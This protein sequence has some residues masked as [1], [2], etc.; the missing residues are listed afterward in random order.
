[1]SQNRTGSTA[2][3]QN[4]EKKATLITSMTNHRKQLPKQKSP[5]HIKVKPII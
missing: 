5:S 3:Q 4:I 2:M 1:M